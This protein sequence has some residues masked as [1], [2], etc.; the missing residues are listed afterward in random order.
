MGDW[1]VGL[2]GPAGAPG[3]VMGE[4]PQSHAQVWLNATRRD[5]ASAPRPRKSIRPLAT[6]RPRQGRGPA[7][8]PRGQRAPMD[9]GAAALDIIAGST[10]VHGRW[11]LGAGAARSCSMFLPA[12][13]CLAAP[14][15]MPRGR[16]SANTGAPNG[17]R[18][19]SAEATP[20]A[21]PLSNGCACT[22]LAAAQATWVPMFVRV[23]PIRA[24]RWKRPR[25]L[26]GDHRWL[27]TGRTGT[28][29]SSPPGVYGRALNAFQ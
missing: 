15:V 14:H 10:W 24:P 20:G 29:S 26:A 4:S 2:D 5:G 1:C 16:P 17:S 7:D 3:E 25:L 12:R 6:P 23:P 11:G 13:Q 22:V 19:L 18:P 21:T 8:A 27:A 28:T 9:A